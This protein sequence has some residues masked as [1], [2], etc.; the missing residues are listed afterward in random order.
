ML[1]LLEQD[2][3]T[4]NL[5]SAEDI[6]SEDSEEAVDFAGTLAQIRQRMSHG[7]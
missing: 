3:G 1:E 6:V 5:D 2:F 4:V 7:R